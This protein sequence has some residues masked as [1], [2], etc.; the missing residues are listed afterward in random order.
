M[1]S[2]KEINAPNTE[3]SLEDY[4]PIRERINTLNIMK[5]GMEAA[6]VSVDSFKSVK[7]KKDR[8]L[9]L[10]INL[11]KQGTKDFEN[12]ASIFKATGVLSDTDEIAKAMLIAGME[13]TIDAFTK[14]I[15]ALENLEKQA[16]DAS[17][18]PDTSNQ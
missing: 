18:E 5:R 11:D 16:E 2:E 15:E 6:S 7:I 8:R 17:D 9:K 4:N 3:P 13:S 10:Y 1:Q 12:I 14:E